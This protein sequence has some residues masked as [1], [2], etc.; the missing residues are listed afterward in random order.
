MS[1]VSK[2]DLPPQEAGP[3]MPPIYYDAATKEYLRQAEDGS[4]LRFAE[5]GIRRELKLAGI[6]PKPKEGEFVSD[7]DREISRLTLTRNVAYA[8]PLAG[9][10]AGLIEE[11]GRR[12]LVTESPRLIEPQAGPWPML[13][14]ILRGL[15]PAEEETGDV[16]RTVFLCW[17][18]VAFSAL[19]A[20]RRQPG[21]ALA[22]AGPPGSGKT[23]L[24]TVITWALGGRHARPYR[25]M[26]GLTGF[27]SELFAAEHLIVD[28]E[29][30][31][32]DGRI[33][34]QFGATMKQITVADG[35]R[36]EKKYCDAIDLRP[37][38][39]LTISVN[40][41][42]DA[43][44]VL[45]PITEDLAD[46]ITLL[47]VKRAAM[48]MPTQTNEER[49]AF[50]LALLA[51]MPGFLH[52]VLHTEIPHDLAS[53]R[54]GVREFHHPEI[55]EALGD[56]APERRLLYLID[57]ELFGPM[58]EPWQGTAEELEHELRSKAP[59][60]AARTITWSNAV[61]SY[62]GLLRKSRPKRFDY[63]RTNGERVWT[64]HPMSP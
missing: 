35:A 52:S 1:T 7:M 61:G 60:E 8:A 63:R 32:R 30:A 55:L 62:L 41:E 10:S 26:S 53:Q 64:I 17:L 20:R 56:I 39:R 9:Y 18:K 33:R 38:W 34:A 47:R 2:Y 15:F 37:F 45:P 31:S 11:S 13:D 4:W 58:G 46:K 54:F 57:R 3:Q 44:A 14:A 21:Q 59:A 42:P 49:E 23:L 19:R 36:C 43:L 48:P 28:D 12:I 25:Y 16:Q 40:D 50:R 22:L 51:E 6:R 24:Q 5:T 29:A 27:N